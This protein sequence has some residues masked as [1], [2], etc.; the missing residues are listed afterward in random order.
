MPNA[1]PFQY[2]S[3]IRCCFGEHTLSMTGKAVVSGGRKKLD[4][5]ISRC[6]SA[7]WSKCR[8]GYCHIYDN[9]GTHTKLIF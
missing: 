5:P 6:S 7:D 3:H 8:K 9:R 1:R 4:T 2:P